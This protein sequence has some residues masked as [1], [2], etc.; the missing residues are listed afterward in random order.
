MA[1]SYED[2]LKRVQSVYGMPGGF[3]DGKSTM[4]VQ[5]TPDYRRTQWGN[6]L[7]ND[8]LTALVQAGVDNR[9]LIEPVFDPANP[10]TSKVTTEKDH[11]GNSV[12]KTYKGNFEP[13]KGT[14]NFDKVLV[15]FMMVLIVGAQE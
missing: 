15:L 10:I 14:P 9:N 5:S 4:T 11:L 12:T 6:S 13:D 2:Y 3:V 8:D 7:S 1:E